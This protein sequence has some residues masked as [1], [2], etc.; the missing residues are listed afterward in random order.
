M[1]IDSSGSDPIPHIIDGIPIH[2]R[3]VRVYISRPDLTVNPTSCEPFKVESRL[4]GSGAN[5]GTSADDTTAVVSSPYQ[6]FNCGSVP[7]KPRLKLRLRGGT[8]R[9]AFPALRAELR[10]RPGDANIAAAKVTLPPSEFLEQRHIKTIC[11]LPQFAAETCPSESVYGSAQ[12]LSPLL[13]QPL[14]GPVYLR[15]S[16]GRQ[17]PDLVADLHG[18]GLG[19]RIEVVGHID[20][21]HGGLRGTFEGIPD[22]AVSR[23]V[24]N[25]E[26]G[27][28]GLL[29]NSQDTCAG[30]QHAD[31]RFVG[32]NNVG[33]R[34]R[35]TIEV[36]C[37]KSKKRRRG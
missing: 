4:T 33:I 32:H 16:P 6:A 9:G 36:N 3:D 2:L 30:K 31:A 8:G 28:R 27:K 25:L 12:A 13:A 35:P 1:S 19:L 26:G 7:F 10:P 24:L 18:G 15:A 37:T 34:L 22:A 20:S 14:Q 5:F 11:T 17:L 21:I 23:F 29:V